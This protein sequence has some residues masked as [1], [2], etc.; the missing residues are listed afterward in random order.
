MGQK[1]ID[2]FE[3]NDNYFND[4][5][6]IND[7]SINMNESMSNNAY[8]NAG[9]LKVDSSNTFIVD[10]TTHKSIDIDNIDK[11]I[12]IRSSVIETNNANVE[13][14]IFE[15]A[16]RGLY[17]IEGIFQSKNNSAMFIS[18]NKYNIFNC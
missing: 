18:K 1:H 14:G 2:V 3:L 11:V 17:D 6:A 16:D 7:I 15:Y 10:V 12:G 13:S 4:G 8:K 5:Y 9:I